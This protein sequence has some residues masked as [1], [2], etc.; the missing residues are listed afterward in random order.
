[1][2]SRCGL[3]E[4]ASA[5]SLVSCAFNPDWYAQ[6]MNGERNSDMT[7]KKD[8]SVLILCDFDG[9][10]SV[11]DT[12]NRL[13][14]EHL[15]DPEWRFHVKR[16]M[17][18]E[19]GSREV[20]R[21]VAPLMRMNRAQ[22]VEFVDEHADLD[23]YFPAFLQWAAARGID[24][25]ILSDGFDAT[26]LTLFNCH[27]IEGLEIFANS[28]QPGE[29]EPVTIG[30]PHAN[31]DCGWCGTCKLGVL[32]RFRESYDKIILIGD[33]E[34]DRHAAEE[35]DMVVALKDLF[36]YCARKG[37]PAVRADGFHEIPHLLSR[38]I[39]T[40]TFDMDGTLVDSLGTIV[41]S[42][43][44]MFVELG[45]PTMTAE[46]V[47]QKTGISL[48][49]FAKTFLKPGEAEPGI[50]AFRSHYD[51]IYKEK[52]TLIPGA[53]ETLNTLD[54]TV[55][56]GIVTNKKGAYA[57][58]LAEHLGIADNMIRIIGAEDGFKAKPSGDMFKEFMRSAGARKE[59]TIYVG[60][61]PLDIHAAADAGIDAFAVA[62][63]I[64]SAEELALHKP[65]RVLKNIRELPAALR[66]LV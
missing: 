18:G 5:N 11:K 1:M 29:D 54:G 41:E 20:Y 66:P 60:D 52:T 57:R 42:F 15:V 53:A 34:S 63:P 14:R 32:R 43:N 3:S 19:I 50:R 9:T 30:S 35:A 36:L 21:A 44:H 13:V 24:V 39:R 17:R 38:E 51:T 33:G 12:V 37:I 31:S 40:V 46:E 23:P 6:P 25:K 56:Q 27:G 4:S 49:D 10:V 59:E 48:L 47:V 61:A 7:V 58:S 45:Y 2:P 55:I 22:L 8:P 62:N 64:Y 16:Y 65:R 28:L 26:I